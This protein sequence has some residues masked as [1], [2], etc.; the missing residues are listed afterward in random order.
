[1]RCYLG[2]I[3]LLLGL[4][5]LAWSQVATLPFNEDFE[6]GNHFVAT[7]PLPPFKGGVLLD[8]QLH[9]PLEGRSRGVLITT[10]NQRTLFSRSSLQRGGHEFS[11]GFVDAEHKFVTGIVGFGAGE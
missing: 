3:V 11:E 2:L 9:S 1:M 10:V 5:S 7:S 8:G 6:G 4:G